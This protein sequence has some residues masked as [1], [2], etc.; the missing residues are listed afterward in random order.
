VV[1]VVAVVFVTTIMARTLNDQLRKRRLKSITTTTTSGTASSASSS[2]TTAASTET[3]ADN[4]S[5]AEVGGG[6]NSSTSGGGDG[7]LMLSDIRKEKSELQRWMEPLYGQNHNK[8]AKHAGAPPAVVITFESSSSDDDTTR[9]QPSTMMQPPMT[10]TDEDPPPAAAAAAI[11]IAAAAASKVVL[12]PG[13][14]TSSQTNGS[15]KATAIEIDDE[16]DDDE[17]DEEDSNDDEERK[18][19]LRQN[20]DIPYG[21]AVGEVR[22]AAVNLKRQPCRFRAV[23]GEANKYCHLHD[24]DEED[25]DDDD[26]DDD[27][28]VEVDDDDDDDDD[29]S[30]VEVVAV[31]SASTGVLYPLESTPPQETTSRCLA[32]TYRGHQCQSTVDGGERYCVRHNLKLNYGTMDGEEVDLRSESGGESDNNHNN[33]NPSAEDLQGNDKVFRCLPGT[34]QCISITQRGNHCPQQAVRNGHCCRRH[35]EYPPK[36]TVKPGEVVRS[37]PAKEGVHQ[38]TF[39]RNEKGTIRCSALISKSGLPCAYTTN[40]GSAY[41]SFHYKF[42]EDEE[43]DD[44]SVDESHFGASNTR[45]HNSR[46]PAAVSTQKDVDASPGKESVASTTASRDAPYRRRKGQERCL[47]ITGQKQKQCTHA[48]AN[49][50]LYCYEH[51]NFASADL[52]LALSASSPEEVAGSSEASS[53]SEESTTCIECRLQP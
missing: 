24:D 23:V 28:I 37:P 26:D 5:G 46:P 48:S 29:D 52:P 39:F 12:S 30:I 11:A 27:S 44:S 9:R 42:R 15:S 40:N 21:G 20:Q 34:R 7:R 22:C 25:D 33:N 4:N 6:G 43:E 1:V 3:S 41:C 2:S 35:V 45:E 18:K 50:T 36:R 53:D 14:V 13:T 16:D 47:A 31:R 32:K 49:S 19:T 17:D 51:A 8:K 10:P 38:R